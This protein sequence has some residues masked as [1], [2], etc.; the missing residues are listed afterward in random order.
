MN[1]LLDTC[2]VTELIKD[3]PEIKVVNWISETPDTSLWGDVNLWIAGFRLPCGYGSKVS[4]RTGANSSLPQWK[5]TTYTSD[6]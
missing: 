2:V 3:E 4:S 5:W 1:Y 6:G